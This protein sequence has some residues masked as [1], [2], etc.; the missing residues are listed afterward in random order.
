MA[1]ALFNCRKLR[2]DQVVQGHLGAPELFLM[3]GVSLLVWKQRWQESLDARPGMTT[4]CV[5]GVVLVIG[6]GFAGMR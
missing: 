4:I 3:F 6:L 5:I 1:T 2:Y